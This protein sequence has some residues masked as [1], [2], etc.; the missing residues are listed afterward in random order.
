[1]NFAQTFQ[2]PQRNEQISTC[3]TNRNSPFRTYKVA[4]LVHSLAEGKVISSESPFTTL[5]IRVGTK[6]ISTYSLYICH[7]WHFM[8]ARQ[9]KSG[10]DDTF[11]I[12]NRIWKHS[13]HQDQTDKC[14][15]QSLMIEVKYLTNDTMAEEYI[16]ILLLSIVNKHRYECIVT[17]D[18]VLVLDRA[19]KSCLYALI[20]YIYIH[21]LC[22]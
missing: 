9:D 10:S 15:Q 2:M 17:R 19:R 11:K 8:F 21:L 6:Y 5:A 1:M 7:D 3:K 16:L 13:H 14:E 22:D 20:I 4:L 18:H 12:L